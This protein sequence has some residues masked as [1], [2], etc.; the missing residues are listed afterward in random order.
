MVSLFA[1]S[2]VSRETD[3]PSDDSGGVSVVE[4]MNRRE[5]PAGYAQLDLEGRL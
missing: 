3:P 4:Q 1:A 2:P 5:G